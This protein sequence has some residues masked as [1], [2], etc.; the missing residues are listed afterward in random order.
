MGPEG[1]QTY[2]G[3][4]EEERG[5]HAEESGFKVTVGREEKERLAGHRV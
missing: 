2:G 5:A 3:L 1:S 4:Q